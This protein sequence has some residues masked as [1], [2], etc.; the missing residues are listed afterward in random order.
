MSRP[1]GDRWAEAAAALP[2]AERAARERPFWQ[3]LVGAW[4]WR[5]VADAGCGAGFHL[6]LLRPLGVSATGFD[7]AVAAL[8]RAAGAVAGD[9]LA[10]PLRP[11]IFDAAL[12]LGNTLSLLADRSA[13]RRALTA[14]ASLLRPGGVV[15]LQGENAGALVRQGPVLRTRRVEGSV[16]VRVFERRGRR[17]RMLA[18]VAAG[19]D[20]SLAETW[21]VP[22]GAGDVVRAARRLGLNRIDLPAQPPGVDA[23]WWVALQRSS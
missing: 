8:P 1:G 6:E 16:H 23:A 9:L 7:L 4:G 11:R 18:G 13:Q 10:P 3:A 15:V 22:T 20:A 17:V 21:L 2:T 12:C 5:R 19:N 14:L